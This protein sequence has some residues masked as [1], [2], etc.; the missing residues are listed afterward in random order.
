MPAKCSGIAIALVAIGAL[1]GP[2][3]ATP[4]TGAAD[5]IRLEAPGEEPAA[6]LSDK[7]QFARF[8]P[9]VTDPEHQIDYSNWGAVLGKIVVGLGPSLREGAPRPEGY[10]STRVQRGH[11]S[12]LR[13][14]GARIAYD[15]FG[16]GVGAA[17]TDYRKELER[18]GTELDIASLSRNEQLAFWLNLHNVAII[19]QIAT[20]YPVIIPAQIMI[21]GAPLHDAKFI[22][23]SGVKM[24]PR[25]IRS[26]IVYPNWSDPRVI[27]GFFHG[28][29]GGP[30][31]QPLEFNRGNVGLLLQENA[32]EFVNSLRGVELRKDTLHVSTLYGE[33]SKFYFQRFERDMFEHLSRFAQAGV[34]A[35][36][37]RA[38]RYR[39]TIY[40]D[41][42]ADLA[43]GQKQVIMAEVSSSGRNPIAY[44]SAV[45]VN[46]QRF[47]I[48]RQTKREI[49]RR[50]GQQIWSI[51]VAPSDPASAEEVE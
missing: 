33:A 4:G 49:L 38:N 24:S 16:E 34:A 21:D 15:L 8:I 13:L 51:T 6:S 32:V 39:A 27:Y 43:R 17:L 7:E 47:V 45:P 12:R 50:Q 26:R 23:V 36:M 14:E 35:D 19:E 3:S 2:A 40:E 41:D 28:D 22:E 25:D 44:G 9:R 48:E 30:M 18:V 10:T 20:A 1:A 31:I 37:A 46:I 42:I 29:I 5:A 11:I